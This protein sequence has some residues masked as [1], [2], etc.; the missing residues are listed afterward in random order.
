MNVQWLHSLSEQFETI[1][2][3]RQNGV[4]SP[5]I[6]NVFTVYIDDLLIDQA[7]D[8]TES[9]T[10]LEQSVMQVMLLSLQHFLLLCD[11]CTSFAESHSLPRHI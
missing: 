9:I 4:L 1:F 7:L 8:A 6:R 3:V 2:G 5:I 10:L 11:K